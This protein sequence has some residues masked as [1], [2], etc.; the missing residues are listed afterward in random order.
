MYFLFNANFA[1]RNLQNVKFHN[2]NLEK[3]NFSNMRIDKVIF[4]SSEFDST[5]RSSFKLPPS[6]Q[7]GQGELPLGSETQILAPW[8][9]GYKVLLEKE[10]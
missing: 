4:S 9:Q 7:G 3:S 10:A 8:I 5:R 2:C 6:C 1:E